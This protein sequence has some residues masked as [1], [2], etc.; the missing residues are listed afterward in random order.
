MSSGHCIWRNHGK[1]S[2]SVVV[3]SGHHA[4]THAA[5][6]HSNITGARRALHA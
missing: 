5:I 1:F 4:A 2:T 6:R 3:V